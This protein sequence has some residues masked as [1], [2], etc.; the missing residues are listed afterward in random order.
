MSITFTVTTPTY[1]SFVGNNILGESRD[2]LKQLTNKESKLLL[3]SVSI[4]GIVSL[5]VAPHNTEDRTLTINQFS[6]E[7][8]KLH[9]KLH[10]VEIPKQQPG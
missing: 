7:N 6:V 8:V 9:T 2:S 5:P 10:L 1:Y 3:Q 4:T